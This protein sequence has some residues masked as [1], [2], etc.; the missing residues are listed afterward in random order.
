MPETRLSSGRL[1]TRRWE[2]LPSCIIAEVPELLVVQ[3]NLV[4]MTDYPTIPTSTQMAKI[5]GKKKRRNT[6]GHVQKIRPWNTENSSLF[7]CFYCRLLMFVL[8][9]KLGLLNSC[10]RPKKYDLFNS[11]NNN[12]GQI[13]SPWILE[14]PYWYCIYTYIY[15]SHE[16]TK[17]HDLWP[18]YSREHRP[19][20]LIA[21]V[22]LL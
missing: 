21:I 13:P 9:E 8:V 22:H 4:T 17:I 12:Q 18:E 5:S 3:P 11:K 19:W 2:S 20:N 6:V 1:L 7:R 15:I 16:N 14:C 10:G